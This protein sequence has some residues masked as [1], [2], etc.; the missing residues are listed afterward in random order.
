[1]NDRQIQQSLEE[2]RFTAGLSDDDQRK[3]SAIASTHSFPKGTVL[4]TEGDVNKEVHVIR[5]GR[6]E[7][8]MSVPAR[9]CLPV[10]TLEP[11]DCIGWSAILELGGMTATVV[12]LED[13]ETVSLDADRLRALCDEDHDI[14]YHIM[15]RIAHALSQRLTASRLQ[16][17]D[18]YGQ[19]VFDNQR[20][21]TPGGAL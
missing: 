15:E 9:G 16:M 18:I 7:V 4:Y 1:M 14:G 12:A 13:V 21:E 5:S 8:C 10:L 6:V 19:E 20:N 17:L 3:L 2:L 11:G